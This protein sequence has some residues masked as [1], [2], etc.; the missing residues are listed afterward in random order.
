MNRKHI[1]FLFKIK[2][3]TEAT[4]KIQSKKVLKS[5]G[6]FN[7]K[8]KKSPHGAPGYHKTT[9][10]AAFDIFFYCKFYFYLEFEGPKI[11]TAWGHLLT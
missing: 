1:T 4:L 9:N 2:L 6:E 10:F 8:R 5:S 11:F 3:K 7:G